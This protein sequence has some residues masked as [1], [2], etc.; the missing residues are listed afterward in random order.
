MKIKLTLLFVLTA[1]CLFGAV[2]TVVDWSKVSVSKNDKGQIRFFPGKRHVGY[3][4]DWLNK[5]LGKAEIRDGSLILDATG[6]KDSN[7]YA[8]IYLNAKKYPD[9]MV[10][11]EFDIAGNEDGMK[12]DFYQK[13]AAYCFA[14]ETAE[15]SCFPEFPL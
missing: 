2:E 15:R 13:H 12:V 5:N 3:V 9:Q 1:A 7:T 6:Y 8:M 14:A 4:R 11:I 10:Q